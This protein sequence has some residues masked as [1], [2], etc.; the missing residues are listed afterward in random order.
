[1][2]QFKTLNDTKTIN[3]FIEKRKEKKR[4]LRL[5][6]PCHKCNINVTKTIPLGLRMVA[7]VGG[8]EDLMGTE[9]ATEQT[10][11]QS[12]QSLESLDLSKVERELTE[13]DREAYQRV[14]SVELSP[15]QEERILT[16]PKVRHL[17]E[18]V[19]AVHW[20]REFIPMPLVK[21]RIEA[22]F[23]N[24]RKHL[25]IPTDHNVLN[26]YDEF[27]GVE[28]DCYS[29]EFNVKV[30]L[31]IHFETAKLETSRSD[32]FKSMLEHTF[33]YR[34]SQLYAFLGTLLEPAHVERLEQAAAKTGATPKLIEFV[35]IHAKKVAKMVE[36]MRHETPSVSL[37]NKILRDFFNA[38]REHYD[39]HLIDRAQVFLKAVKKIVKK[40]FKLEYFYHTQEVIEEVKALG[41]CI[42][43][44]HPEQFWPIL[45]ADY[46]VDG[47]EVWNPQSREYTEFLINVVNRHNKTKARKDRRLLVMMGDDCHMGEKVKDPRYWDREKAFREIGIQPPWDDLTIS[48][49][50]ILGN[51]NR[52]SVIDE[53]KE[54]LKS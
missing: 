37:K 17:Q 10:S 23:P 11:K 25:L 34:S 43:I 49:S 6:H 47:Y 39:S 27:T 30:Q 40:S 3:L 33:K 38:M 52:S 46:D 54:R 45:L 35:Q 26:E 14:V 1:M 18:E 15:E 7:S 9:T 21:K 53:Y 22:T 36:E 44:P 4:R 19:L 12:L 50:L 31:L 32:V 8:K 28:V 16:P 13:W 51:F 48:K 42:V 41:G 2:S 5:T 29:P 24:C 20:H